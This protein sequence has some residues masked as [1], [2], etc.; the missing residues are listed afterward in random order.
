M[1][2]YRENEVIDLLKIVALDLGKEISEEEA[3]REID[4]YKASKG[5]HYRWIYCKDDDD[6]L[7]EHY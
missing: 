7:K 5:Y 1:R 6:A 2:L 4:K 3:K